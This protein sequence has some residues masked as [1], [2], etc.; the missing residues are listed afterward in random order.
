MG[1]IIRS[2]ISEE[3]LNEVAESSLCVCVRICMCEGRVG[4]VIEGMNLPRF[5]VFVCGDEVDCY[6]FLWNL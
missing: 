1:C 3:H 2:P 5:P 4:C 6:L